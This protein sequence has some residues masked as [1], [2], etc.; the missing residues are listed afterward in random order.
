MSISTE[1]KKE[2]MLDL[3]Q[4]RAANAKSMGG[5]SLPTLRA[6]FERWLA[7]AGETADPMTPPSR[8]QA[9]AFLHHLRDALPTRTADARYADFQRA[10][11][12]VWGAAETAHLAAALRDV[13]CT[14][15][16]PRR[17][18]LEAAAQLVAI[19]PEPAWRAAFGAVL[20][21]HDPDAPRRPGVPHWSPS[22]I[23]NVARA[24]GAWG[25][26]CRERGLDPRPSGVAMQAYADALEGD[27]VA[28]ISIAAYLDRVRLGWRG[29]IE[30]GAELPGAELVI[31]RWRDRAAEEEGR[32]GKAAR[33]VPASRV[34]E[35]GYALMTEARDAPVRGLEAARTYRNGLLLALATALPQRARALSTLALDQ[36]ITLVAPDEIHIDLPGETLKM[37]EPKKKRTR[38]QEAIVS[39]RLHAALAEY[40]RDFRPIFDA[41]DWLWP[42]TLDQSGPISES[43]I[44]VI[45]GDITERRLG[46][47]VN[48][49]LLRDCVVTEAIERMPDGG[50]LAAP[51]LGHRDPR[52]TAQHYDHAEDVEAVRRLS[53]TVARHRSRAR[54]DPTF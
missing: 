34:H 41:G 27:G 30:P 7:F 11:A 16:A 6:V 20:A 8:R 28:A 10:A 43:R 45:C 13:R 21:R 24:L 47:R 40:R 17:T 39:A 48:V 37:R 14:M 52:T 3:L 18:P 38:F 25:G 42:S 53:T 49:H 23:A 29:L 54:P 50:V 26:H 36:T 2:K 44:G 1:E 51:L 15:K 12:L 4:G 5:S 33:I 35:L 9:A 32:K 22:H 19:L 46:V 31:A